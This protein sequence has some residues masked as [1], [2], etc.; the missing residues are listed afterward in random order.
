MSCLGKISLLMVVLLLGCT[1]PQPVSLTPPA[2][3]PSPVFTPLTA[4]TL[5]N[6][7]TPSPAPLP[8][9]IFIPV[10]TPAPTPEPKRAPAFTPAPEITLKPFNTPTATSPL[11]SPPIPPPDVPW[12]L[13]KGGENLINNAGWQYTETLLS[14]ASGKIVV[15]PG[16][17]HRTAYN[18]ET[19]L[20]VRFA[21]GV[22]ATMDNSTRD[23]GGIVLAGALAYKEYWQGLKSIEV[24]PTSSGVSVVMR[25]GDSPKLFY[26]RTFPV[27]G[28]ANPVQIEVRK[29]GNQFNIRVNGSPVAWVDDPGLFENG[30]LFLGVIT[31]PKNRLTI[32]SLSISTPTGQEDNVHID[33]PVFTGV[34]SPSPS[35]TALLD[36][37]SSLVLP[38]E[39]TVLKNLR[40]G[41][42]R[43]MLLDED[44]DRLRAYINADPVMRSYLR[45]MKRSAIG[46]LEDP[47]V[48]RELD[49]REILLDTSRKVLDRVYTLALLYRLE[50]D[51]RWAERATTEMLAVARFKDWH[52]AHFLD[53][54]EMSYAMAIGYDWLYDTLS[55]QDREEIR[56][57]IVEK[58]LR[59]ALR[60]YQTKEWWT[61]AE[62]NWNIVCNGGIIIAALSV[63]DSEPELSQQVLTRALSNLP[64]ALVTYA[65]D[66]A[67]PE[68]PGYWSYATQYLVAT[69]S[70][71]EGSLGTDFGL[72]SLPGISDTGLFRMN[73]IGPTG[74]SFSFADSSVNDSWVGDESLL[75]WLSQRY[76]QPVLSWAGREAAA[77]DFGRGGGHAASLPGGI[78][79]Y[80]SIGTVNDVT[81]RPLDIFYKD[82]FIAFRRSSW[83]DKNAL[84][85]GFK[86]GD[87]RVNHA[88]LDLGTFVFD[89]LGQRWAID[90]GSDNYALPD[91]FGKQRWTYYRLR[92]E[93]HNTL[94]IDGQNQDTK[95]VAPFVTTTSL[96][97]GG[98]AIVDL[99]GAYAPSGGKRIRRGIALVDGRSRVIVEDEVEA[100][101][102][103]EVVWSMHSR[104][105]I[106]LQGKRAIMTQ[107]GAS[108]QV[109]LLSPDGA[110]FAVEPVNLA[111]PQISST[112]VSKLLVRLPQKTTN[113]RITVLLTPG[114]K[115]EPVSVASLDDWVVSGPLKR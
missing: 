100:T 103:V 31:A 39:Q 24:R 54:A 97:D 55:P 113:V 38:T 91:Y 84:F 52:P 98:F 96:K 78:V 61:Q 42:P 80:D 32:E 33:W 66:G 59:P 99:S 69:L 92:T 40:S 115:A 16:D 20:K 68:G 71:L 27:K 65:S 62:H 81:N 57:A 25:T 56:Q 4:P 18:E 21:W 60:A 6:T 28:L 5:A 58:G 102:P 2:V 83:L 8:S 73:S 29:I 88:H 46:M 9:P 72:G 95:A 49:I 47:P 48:K 109:Q 107:G 37:P 53:V 111:P 75:F 112:G 63:A 26:S 93:G 79:W 14:V 114:T 51:S 50:G 1:L 90:L 13:V 70:A 101:H 86:G 74:L 82:K 17:F 43:L 23:G 108:L 44:V 89:A 30:D 76:G 19:L 41:H 15:E 11:A 22:T 36:R 94:F 3:E 7:S 35:R 110:Y 77:R 67:W 12:T 45:R 106:E 87:N 34:I 10:P 85:V 105:K 64:Y 104:A